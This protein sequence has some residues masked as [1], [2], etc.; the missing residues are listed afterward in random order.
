MITEM[1]EEL[2]K[3]PLIAEKIEKVGKFD[4]KFQENPEAKEREYEIETIHEYKQKKLRQDIANRS[5]GGNNYPQYGLPKSESLDSSQS[6]PKHE[7]GTG[8]KGDPVKDSGDDMAIDNGDD[9]TQ[10]W[11]TLGVMA[12]GVAGIYAYY[13]YKS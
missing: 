7:S 4:G 2:Q 5:G 12:M 8:M 3:N 11:A 6:P 13:K 1:K 10:I 9:V